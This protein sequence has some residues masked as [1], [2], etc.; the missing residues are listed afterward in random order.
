MCEIFHRKL[1]WKKKKAC[2][3][4]PSKK[5]CFS[6]VLVQFKD[7]AALVMEHVSVEVKIHPFL[8]I[9]IS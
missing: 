9:G 8:F 6:F 1:Y 4:F 7:E 3:I 2:Q 5:V